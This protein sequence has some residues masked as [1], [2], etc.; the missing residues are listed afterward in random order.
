MSTEAETPEKISVKDLLADKSDGS[1]YVGR[2]THFM[3]T[4]DI[5][6]FFV[7]GQKLNECIE[8]VGKY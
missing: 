8:L 3:K 6:N 2:V 1:T 4:T 7:T 5:K